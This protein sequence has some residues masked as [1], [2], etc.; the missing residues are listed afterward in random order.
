M[1]PGSLP[2]LSAKARAMVFAEREILPRPEPERRRAVVRARSVLWQAR[3]SSEL[4]RARAPVV[5]WWKRGTLAALSLLGATSAY[6][7]WVA[8]EPVGSRD[9]GAPG[10]ASAGKGPTVERAAPR[11]TPA[12]HSGQAGLPIPRPASADQAGP[13][14]VGSQ[15]IRRPSSAKDRGTSSEELALLDRAR[16]AVVVGDFRAALHGIEKHARSFPK[17]QLGEEREA[18][19][20]RALAG[21]GLSKQAGQAARDFASSYPHSVLL[22]EPRSDDRTRP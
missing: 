20:V 13:A 7:A 14:Q 8:F 10:S 4:L 18:L 1:T 5:A 9:G 6:A 21:A 3:Q 2:P 12:P 22:P 17:S 16:R 15:S 19:R 11:T